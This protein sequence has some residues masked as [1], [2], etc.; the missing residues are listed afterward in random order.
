MTRQSET[1][2]RRNNIPQQRDEMHSS[3]GTK[4]IKHEENV[5]H[6][7]YELNGEEQL[8]LRT[9]ENMHAIAHSIATPQKPKLEELKFLNHPTSHHDVKVQQ[10]RRSSSNAP[11]SRSSRQPTPVGGTNTLSQAQYDA[12]PLPSTQGNLASRLEDPTVP[13]THSRVKQHGGW[14]CAHN[15]HPHYY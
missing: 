10:R 6:N 7:S 3:S 14:L 5:V 11:S 9:P 4:D 2:M 12:M 13:A 1:L 15:I 8:T